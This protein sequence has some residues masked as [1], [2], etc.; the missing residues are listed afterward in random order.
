M[1]KIIHGTIDKKFNVCPK[2]K[3]RGVKLYC[4]DNG[5]NHGT[6]CKECFE[7]KYGSVR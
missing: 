6:I 5:K 2:C 3:K 7:K 1:N 4:Y